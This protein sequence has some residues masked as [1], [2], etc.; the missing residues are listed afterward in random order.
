MTIVNVG[1][2]LSRSAAANPD[3]IAVAAA[4]KQRTGGK[5]RQYDTISF[6][7]LESQTSQ[8][9]AGLV[10][11][12]ARPGM[13][14]A[15]LVPPGIE[16]IKLVF[17]MFKSGVVTVLIDPGMG[18]KNMIQ[19]LS[20]VNPEGF[21]AVPFAQAARCV[22]RAKFAT[23]KFNITVGRRWFWGG[24]TLRQIEA[25]GKN[26]RQEHGEFR[27]E[28]S[29]DDPAAVIF[30][31]GSTGPPKGVLYHHRN[32]VKQ[33][34][35]LRDYYNIAPGGIDISGFPLFAL[36][37]SGMGVTT[38]VP[39][40][41]FTKPAD[42][43]PEE[44]LTAI[45]DFKANQSFGSPALWTT[46]GRYCE[47]RQIRLPTMQR[48]LTAGAPV[49]P[50]V[51]QR[52]QSIISDD[53][54][55]HTP[56]GATEALPIASISSRTVLE[57][58]ATMTQMGCGTCV[59]HRFPGIESRIIEITDSPVENI[60]EAVELPS[61]EIGELIVRGEV[62]T[63]EYITR[64]NANALHKIA[65]HDTVWH[66]MGDVGY[67]D[68]KE[69]F[70]FCGRKGHRV[71]TSAGILFTVPCEAIFNCHSSV[72]RSA[73]VGIPSTDANS[74]GDLQ[75][76]VIVIEFWPESKPSSKD[77]ENKIRSELKDLAMANPLTESIQ[78]F[79]YIDKMPV[80]I[81]HNSKIFRE[82]LAVWAASKAGFF[83][84]T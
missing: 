15:L 11:A 78:I 1:Q 12:G 77:Q 49:P 26:A 71:I 40:M 76:P 84:S 56:Y 10:A 37:N 28:N 7:E 67:L 30:T 31:T 61:G 46:V 19:C 62:V 50:H 27:I 29:P 24:K 23:A 55:I 69:R 79:L 4:S 6:A 80:D 22:L 39:N 57:E 63:P 65:D 16:F 58:T 17:A 44:I 21:V 3:Q 32:F 73:L 82:K 36:F 72:Y 66:R 5:D 38:V 33:V 68:K 18:R 74:P 75:T 25:L 81:R 45:R 20:E 59:G 13:R 53:G 42:V 51:L 41:D 83:F 35:E 48:I 64:G 9:A 52:L 2:L 43:D 60:D 70:W 54:E 8:I 14:L 34:A 47:K